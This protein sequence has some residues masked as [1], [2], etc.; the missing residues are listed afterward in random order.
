[1]DTATTT[2][3]GTTTPGARVDIASA[4]TTTGATPAVTSVR[5]GSGGSFSA[6]VPVGFGDDAITATATASG[7]RSTGYAQVSVIG[8]V[9]GGT[10]VLAVTHPSGTDNGPG[11]YQYPTS[12]DFLPG[13]FDLTG[14]QVITSGSTVYLRADIGNVAPTF[15]AAFGAQLL[16]VYVHNPAAA[17]TSTNAAFSTRNYS[18]ASAGAWSELVEAQGFAAP[19]WTSPGGG[20]V[21][22][23][24]Q[25]VDQATNTITIALPEAEFGTP[26]PGWA[27]SVVLTGQ[28]GFAPGQARQFTATPGAFTFGVCAS[29]NTSPICSVSPD[30]VPQAMDVITPPGVDQDTELNPVPG[31][32]VIQ[33]V[34]VP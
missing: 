2:V 12:P 11:T 4:D 20:S 31:P 7:G 34:V 25:V 13:A 22:T 16:D 26:G 32:V 5:A 27:F 29:G 8:D 18:I 1:M 17:Q 28:D 9:T 3:T 33:P 30:L 10:T 15:G 23:A 14:F 19:S 24:F 21:G 6:T